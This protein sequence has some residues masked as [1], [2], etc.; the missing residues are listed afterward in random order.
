MNQ[1]PVTVDTPLLISGSGVKDRPVSQHG[2][3]FVRDMEDISVA[4]LAWIIFERGIGLLAIFEVIIFLL[5]EM[6]DDIPDPVGCLGIEKLE[7]VEGG[8]EVAVHTV[9]HKALGIVHMGGGLPRVKGELDLMAGG[10]ELWG[11]GANKGVI[12]DAEDR[13]GDDHTDGNKDN[14][15]EVFFHDTCHP[16]FL[17]E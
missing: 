9:G 13:E 16:F 15:F 10:A 8:G 3:T 5:K 11:G 17:R 1:I 6:H 2:T 4:L 14:P 12:G 7:G